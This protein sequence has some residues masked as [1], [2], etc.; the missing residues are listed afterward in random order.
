MPYAQSGK[1]KLYYEETGSGFPILF[2]HEYGSDFREWESQVRHFS[3]RYRCVTYNARGYPPSDVPATDADYGYEFARDDA[4]AVL[5]HLGIKKAYIVGLSQG[6]YATLQFGLRYP[7]MAKAL[8]VAGVGS[9]SPPALRAEFVK[10]TLASA[11]AF[12]S[13][14][15]AAVAEVMANSPT[16][17][18]LKAKDPRGYE[19]FLAHLREHSN[20]GM[21]LVGRN[22]Q[23]KRPSLEDFAAALGQFRMPVLLACGDEDEPCIET[24]IWLKRV[25]PTAGLWM[26]PKTGHAINLEE[27][28]A[29]NRALEDFFAAAEN[30]DWRAR[31]S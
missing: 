29:F 17:I 4:A 7:E 16:R 15:S 8:V 26:V 12:L 28:A 14:G 2:I 31:E 10:N 21:S 13:Q 1:A 22:Y 25:I 23:A 5:N 24:N 9:G 20:V 6:A 18:Q 19:Q 30:G 3:R 27:P 11:E